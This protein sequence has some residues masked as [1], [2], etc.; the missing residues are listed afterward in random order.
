MIDLFHIPAEAPSYLYS[1]L[2]IIAK[3]GGKTV[4][5]SSLERF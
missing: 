5:I 1:G 4:L 3:L 2:K